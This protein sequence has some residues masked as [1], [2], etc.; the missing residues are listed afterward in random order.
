MGA[1]CANEEISSKIR[2]IVGETLGDSV[3]L[4]ELDFRPADYSKRCVW[5]CLK[6]KRGSK[7]LEAE[8]VGA[9]G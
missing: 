1:V 3:H 9:V 6:P 2:K 8:N 5:G 7:K 4:E